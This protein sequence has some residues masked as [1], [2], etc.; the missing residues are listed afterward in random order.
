MNTN[1]ELPIISFDFDGVMHKSVI[2]DTTHPINFDQPNTW[3]PFEKMHTLLKELSKTNKIIVVTKR[4]EYWRAYTQFY[5]NKY[6]LPVTDLYHTNGYDKWD[7]L[8]ELN[9]IRHYD[10]DEYM[11][12]EYEG[13]PKKSSVKLILVNVKTEALTPQN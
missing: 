10:D 8:E 5:I 9:V 1:K 13:D 4:P 11:I 12:D 6:E 2:G 7:L 3:T